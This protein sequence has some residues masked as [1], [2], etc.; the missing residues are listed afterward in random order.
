MKSSDTALIGL[1][2]GRS[3]ATTIGPEGSIVPSPAAPSASMN[4]FITEPWV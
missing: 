3:S 1:L 2:S 4:G